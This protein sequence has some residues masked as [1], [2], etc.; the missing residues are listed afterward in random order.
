MNT[1]HYEDIIDT[2]LAEY[3]TEDGLMNL[4]PWAY[5]IE[6][7]NNPLDRRA[8]CDNG[9]LV[10]AIFVQVSLDAGVPLETFRR[11]VERALKSIEASPGLFRRSQYD[12]RGDSH[13]NATAIV[14]LSRLYGLRYHHDIVA[15][16]N[17]NWY[18]FN[19][20]SP[21]TWTI[22]NQRQGGEIFF[23][24]VASMTPSRYWLISPFLFLWMAVGMALAKRPDSK[25]L[26]WLKLRTLGFD[27]RPRLENLLG[28]FKPEH[29][30]IE[31][32]KLGGA[33]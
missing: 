25:N 24:L 18:N 4:D 12:Y 20:V 11:Q 16:G 23:Y 30:V 17:R 1:M 10:L 21:G 27:L 9:I 14:F 15:Y 33:K 8:H 29:P 7:G 19:V 5:F 26:R 2:A 3:T 28:F 22:D 32:A 31:M 6:R 13:D